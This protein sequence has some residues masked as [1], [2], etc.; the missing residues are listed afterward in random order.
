MEVSRARL[1]TSSGDEFFMLILPVF[2]MPFTQHTREGQKNYRSAGRAPSRTI[3]ISFQQLVRH[4]KSAEF[5]CK[6]YFR[7]GLHESAAAVTKAVLPGPQDLLLLRRVAGIP[8]FHA[9][10]STPRQ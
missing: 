4:T 8:T 10:H 9:S 3:I 2:G 6:L 1:P 5:P 7:L